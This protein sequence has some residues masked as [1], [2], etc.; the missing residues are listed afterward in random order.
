MNTTPLRLATGSH[1][2]GSGK[3]CAMNVVSWENGDTNITDLPA[4]SDLMLAKLVQRVND[5]YCEHRDGD[6]LCPSCSIAVLGLAHR[7]VGTSA[8]GLDAETLHKVWVTIA[9]EQA[10]SVLHIFE[11]ECPGDDRPRKAI[12]AIRAW[13][14]GGSRPHT[15]AN[16]DYVYA[17]IDS[18]A[19]A[20]SAAYAAAYADASVA[21]VDADRVQHA[22]KVIDRFLELAPPKSDIVLPV[23]TQTALERMLA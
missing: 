1:E 3:G 4:C 14:A 7:T 10:E 5:N 8:H 15:A 17:G 21:A 19:Y 11:A 18:D 20:A 16:D 13:L 23:D 12:E 2:A 9:V 6:L 22:H